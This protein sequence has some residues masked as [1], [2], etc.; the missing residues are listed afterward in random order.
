MNIPRSWFCWLIGAVVVAGVAACGSVMPAQEPGGSSGPTRE[1]V[2]KRYMA[3]IAESGSITRSEN[4]TGMTPPPEAQQHLS[5][6]RALRT[7]GR[8]AA[9]AEDAELADNARRIEGEAK[10]VVRRLSP[11]D[12]NRRA[13][14]ITNPLYE[15]SAELYY[16]CNAEIYAAALGKNRPEHG[17]CAR[18]GAPTLDGPNVVVYGSSQNYIDSTCELVE[19]TKINDGCSFAVP[20]E[21]PTTSGGVFGSEEVATDHDTC[22]ALFETGRLAEDQGVPGDG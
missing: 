16:D 22:R 21:G 12:T 9:D 15:R 6:A 19:G 1:T 14:R 4:S 11:T 18:P 5:T 7:F 17:A 2:C 20:G 13:S 8:W 3:V 10:R